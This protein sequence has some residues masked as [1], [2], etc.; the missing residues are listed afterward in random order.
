MSSDLNKDNLQQVKGMF[1][2]AVIGVLFMTV[3]GGG[4]IY[5]ILQKGGNMLAT[6]V[7]ILILGV[8][9]S[10]IVYVSILKSSKPAKEEKKEEKKS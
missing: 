5:T 10:G 2:T 1:T 4:I 7:A 3:V 8:P 9:L 6:V